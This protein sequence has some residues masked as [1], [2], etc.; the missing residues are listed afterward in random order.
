MGQGILD[1][2]RV[3]TGQSIPE[4]GAG[5]QITDAGTTEWKSPENKKDSS[6]RTRSIKIRYAGRLNIWLG[7]GD[8]GFKE[9][10][11]C[12]TETEIELL[13]WK[14]LVKDHL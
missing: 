10:G 6:G 13:N 12:C 9:D 14:R 7:S 8:G 11:R 1:N 5:I 4:P 2:M 3:C